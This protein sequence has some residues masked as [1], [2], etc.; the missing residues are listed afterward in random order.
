M[1]IR[2]SIVIITGA[3]SGIGAASARELARQGATLVLAA[4]RADHLRTLADE[5][6]RLGG[7]ALVVA[8]DVTRADEIERLVQ[9]TITTYGRIDVLVNNAG[10]EEELQQ[11][12]AV[13]LLAPAR[14]IRAVVPHMRQRGGVIVNIGSVA[15]EVG[16]TSIYSATKFGLRG[17]SDSLRR[18]LRQHK[19]AVVLIE[20]GYV[21]TPMTADVKIPMPGPSIVAHAVAVAIQRPRRKIIVPWYYA[22][23]AYLAKLAPW[24]ADW[25]LSRRPIQQMINRRSASLN[26]IKP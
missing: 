25:I 7:K 17:M 1:N 12:V 3:S 24:L 9:T 20:P 23:L 19:I 10:A 15:G 8:T 21:R 18:E 6:E 2:G 4:R 11:I 16:T 26:E 14:T 13:N 5:I 22:P